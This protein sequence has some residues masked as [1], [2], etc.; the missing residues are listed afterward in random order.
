MAAKKSSALTAALSG[1]PGSE[2]PVHHHHAPKKKSFL[3]PSA[4]PCLAY[5]AQ[6]EGIES[7]PEGDVPEED[8]GLA[9]LDKIVVGSVPVVFPVGSKLVR[10]NDTTCDQAMP[11]AFTDPDILCR[12]I[13]S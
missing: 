13:T 8:L 2:A 7:V 9:P 12:W 6:V 3:D 5:A 4:F 1:A 11:R 10:D